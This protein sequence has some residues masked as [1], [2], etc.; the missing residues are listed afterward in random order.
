MS[1]LASSARRIA[2]FLMT[3]LLFVAVVTICADAAFAADVRVWGAQT[4]LS[5]EDAAK[6]T[7]LRLVNMSGTAGETVYFTVKDSDRVLAQHLPHVL[8]EDGQAGSE[9]ADTFSINLD[10]G[11]DETKLGEG[12]YTVEAYDKRGGTQLYQGAVYGVWARIS[13]PSGGAGDQIILI[14]ARTAG[15]TEA[16]SFIPPQSVFQDGAAYSL[17][18]QTPIIEGG[19]AFFDYAPYDSET[20]VDGAI[21]YVDEQ[22]ALLD[23][24]PIPGIPYNGSKTQEIPATIT[25]NGKLYR[26]LALRDSVEAVNPGQTSF[27]VQCAYMRGAP[28][29]AKIRMVDENDEVLATDTLNVE[30]HYTYTAPYAIYKNE[31]VDGQVRAVAYNLAAQ[32]TYEFDADKDMD[33]VVNGQRTV[34]IAYVRQELDP[35]EIEVTFNQLDGQANAEEATRLLGTQT[36]T[37][38]AESPEATPANEIEVEGTTYVLTTSPQSYQY[39]FGSG[40]MPVIDVYYVPEG[41][42][43]SDPYEVTVN[44]VDLARGPGSDPVASETYTSTPDPMVIELDAPQTFSRDGVDYVRLGNQSDT[45]PHNYFSHVQTYTVY[46][47]DVNN[48]LLAN[49]VITRTRVVNGGTTTVTGA[50]AATP[51]ATA[52][53]PAATTTTPAATPATNADGTTAATPAATPAAAALNPATSYNAVDGDGDGTLLNEEGVDSNTERIEEEVTPLANGEDIAGA[54]DKANRTR[55]IGIVIGALAVLAA[56]II[57]WL[58]IAARRRKKDEEKRENDDA[59]S[60]LEA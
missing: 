40:E 19:A 24:T 4:T 33:Q 45:I 20:S 53:T 32:G 39:M 16:F 27:I 14:G 30:D 35:A 59:A 5:Q 10:S 54:N 44:Y 51:A 37:V 18:S 23:T 47:R 1:H 13:D 22:G 58:V 42:T 28:Y 6:G 7:E 36:V 57:A 50:T 34:T 46:Y 52:T 2:V 43:G 15:E 31:E 12:A 29:V 49:T 60:G 21:S 3:A 25:A 26:T 9:V 17:T 8:G 55:T 38:N 48:E 41:Y 11:L 56:G